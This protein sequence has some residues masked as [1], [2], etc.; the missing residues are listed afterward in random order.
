MDTHAK[1][2]LLEKKKKLEEYKKEL[3]SFAKSD[4]TGF[5]DKIEKKA[6]VKAF[7]HGFVTGVILLT[8]ILL[9]L[10]GIVS[11]F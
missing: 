5:I 4:I 11:L 3:I 10:K 9:M 6:I 1:I 7:K 2:E 8:I